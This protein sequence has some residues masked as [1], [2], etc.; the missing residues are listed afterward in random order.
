MAAASRFFPGSYTYIVET[1]GRDVTLTG[2]TELWADLL[3][4]N[5]SRWFGAGFESFFLGYRLDVLWNKYWWQ[6]NEAH[7]GY[8]EVYLNL[9]LIGLS[10]LFVVLLSGYRRMIAAYQQDQTSGML[11]AALFVVILI[12]NTTESA[13]RG[14]HPLWMAFVIAIAARVPP[15]S[16][17]LH[18]RRTSTLTPL[19]APAAVVRGR[20]SAP[21][22]RAAAARAAGEFDRV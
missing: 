12:Y 16:V 11:L 8:L 21:P 6:P 2:R 15:V 13:F 9:G 17:T 3:S 1:V 18:S 4:L 20:V 19:K 5:P 10:L 7:N 22:A 14:M